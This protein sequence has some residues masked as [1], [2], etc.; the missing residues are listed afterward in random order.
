MQVGDQVQFLDTTGGGIVTRIDKK[1][2]LVYVRDEDGFEVPTHE[3]QVVVISAKTSALSAD[4]QP[5]AIQHE[6]QPAENKN[7]KNHAVDVL[8]D[9]Q[10]TDDDEYETDYGDTLNVQLAFMPQNMRFLQSTPYDAILVNDSNYYLLYS[11]AT[12]IDGKA[13]IVVNG[14]LEPNMTD[15]FTTITKDHLNEWEKIRIQA[16]PFKKKP[17][18]AQNVIDVELKL[19]LVSFFKLHAFTSNE[20][21]DQPAWLINLTS[22]KQQADF[23]A[24]ENIVET[25]ANPFPTPQRHRRINKS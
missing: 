20:Y 11:V 23:K 10:E 12:I 5:A 4:A 7:T 6:E 2:R 3:S 22:Q 16:I 1:A 24:L 8:T 9:L 14:V 19:N 15:S 21:F 17:Y 18:T 13:Q 25:P